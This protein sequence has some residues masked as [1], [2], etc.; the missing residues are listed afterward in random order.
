MAIGSLVSISG[1]SGNRV[2]LYV[3]NI[4]IETLHVGFELSVERHCILDVG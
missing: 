1:T 3:A 2:V 4:Y